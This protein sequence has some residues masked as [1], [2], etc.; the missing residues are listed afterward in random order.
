M[1]INL[2]DRK[3]QY[4][5]RI[6]NT[7]PSRPVFIFPASSLSFTFLG[8]GASVVIDNQRAYWDIL[9]RNHC[10]WS[11]KKERLADTGSR[12]IVLAETWRRRNTV[13]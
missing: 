5:G 4:S 2:D 13:L 10:G 3:L 11:T 1:K 7:D 12:K 9:Y 8:T 6:D